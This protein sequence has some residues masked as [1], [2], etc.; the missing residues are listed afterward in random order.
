ME[1]T[2][3]AAAS[4]SSMAPPAKIRKRKRGD[5]EWE[6]HKLFIKEHYSLKG[7][8]SKVIEG[9]LLEKGFLVR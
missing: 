2:N 5:D 6:I 3:E 4:S 8:N 9:M 1:L 7:V